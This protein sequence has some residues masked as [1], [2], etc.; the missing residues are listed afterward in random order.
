MRTP[1]FKNYPKWSSAKFWGHIRSALRR[2]WVSWPPRNE[3]KNKAKVYAPEGRRKY[4][5]QC[6]KCKEL[7]PGNDV[8]VDHIKECG[9][10]QSF[11]DLPRFVETLFSGVDNLQVLCTKCHKE[12]K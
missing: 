12:K 10:L 3:V 5:Y 4:L 1:P 11:E 9:S 2:R 6:A 7:Y 8:Q